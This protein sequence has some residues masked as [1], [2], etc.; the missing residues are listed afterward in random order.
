MGIELNQ[1]N[2][3]TFYA[4]PEG[5]PNWIGYSDYEFSKETP[6]GKRTSL[7]EHVKAAL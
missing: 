6:S 7:P 1:P 3:K 4:T 5:K 2:P